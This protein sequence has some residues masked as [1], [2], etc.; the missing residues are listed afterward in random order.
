MCARSR[1]F[2]F[3]LPKP[4]EELETLKDE[5]DEEE[6]EEELLLVVPRAQLLQVGT[7]K[8]AFALNRLCLKFNP[9]FSTRRCGQSRLEE[10][11]KKQEEVQRALDAAEREMEREK[12]KGRRARG[13]WERERDAMREVITELRDSMRENYE[14]MK[15]M[16]GKH[17]V[18]PTFDLQNLKT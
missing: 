9:L 18:C 16:E 10:C 8:E 6:G 4:L 14:K 13:E 15:K 5:E 11:V 3:G 17:K 12:E 2:T 7:R 1:P